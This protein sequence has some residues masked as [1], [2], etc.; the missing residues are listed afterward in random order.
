MIPEVIPAKAIIT[1]TRRPAEVIGNP[2][3][4]SWIAETTRAEGR[5]IINPPA[6]TIDGVTGT[7]IMKAPMAMEVATNPP[8]ASE[9]NSGTR[10]TASW[11]VMPST[12]SVATK[13]SAASRIGAPRKLA[14]RLA[15]T[16][17]AK[18]TIHRG[19]GLGS[20]VICSSLSEASLRVMRPEM[21]SVTSSC[22]AA[23][24]L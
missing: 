21:R 6:T 18:V 22:T 5:R 24:A 16:A 3:I 12:T 11:R 20:R 7:S 15:K 8:A 23:S 9:K 14:N 19:Y 10:Q 13:P 1:E 17:P 2:L 4:A